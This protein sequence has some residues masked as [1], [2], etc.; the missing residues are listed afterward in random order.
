[1]QHHVVQIYLDR[2]NE[3]RWRR[4]ASNGQI[5]ADSG[6]GYT[7]LSETHDAIFRT[8]GAPWLLCDNIDTSNGPAQVAAPPLTDDRDF[9]DD[10]VK[11]EESW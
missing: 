3:F 7:E 8:F 2:A 4:I 1:M 9:Q 10:A 5:I 11:D 6:E